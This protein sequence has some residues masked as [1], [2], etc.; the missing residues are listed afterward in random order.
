MV[1]DTKIIKTGQKINE[2]LQMSPNKTVLISVLQKTHQSPL[3]YF[4]RFEES[5]YGLFLLGEI[6]N[7][8]VI[9]CLISMSLVLLDFI[10]NS[11]LCKI[12]LTVIF[13]V[14]IFQ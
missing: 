6:C 10:E 13:E 7:Y 4:C 3:L 14:T 2:S 8:S 9:Y 5:R 11:Y 1:N 12:F